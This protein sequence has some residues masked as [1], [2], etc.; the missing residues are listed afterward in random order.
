[1]GWCHVTG[2]GAGAAD[3]LAQR[4]E[5]R[6]CAPRL[7][8]WLA[9]DCK[10]RRAPVGQSSGEDKSMQ[11]VH[12]LNGRCRQYLMAKRDNKTYVISRCAALLAG[13]TAKGAKALPRLAGSS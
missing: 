2:L 5:R 4:T 12:L 3:G 9:P 1:M 6:R 13:T 11:E 7:G 10:L 8:P